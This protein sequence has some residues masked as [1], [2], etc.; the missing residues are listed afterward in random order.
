MTK[1]KRIRQKI[2]SKQ[3]SPLVSQQDRLKILAN[4]IID[5]ILKEEVHG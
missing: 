3:K 5:R 1:V 2:T 4:L